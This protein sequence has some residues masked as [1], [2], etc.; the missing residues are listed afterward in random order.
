[1]DFSMVT[2]NCAAEDCDVTFKVAGFDWSDDYTVY[3]HRHAKALIT[4][5][6]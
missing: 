3:C 6:G 2:V 1:M 4:N 5:K